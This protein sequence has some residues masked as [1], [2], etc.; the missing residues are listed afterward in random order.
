MIK[1]KRKIVKVAK[2]RVSLQIVVVKERKIVERKFE[3]EV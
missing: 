1:G 3:K 2:T